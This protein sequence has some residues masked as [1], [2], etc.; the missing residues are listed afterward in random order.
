MFPLFERTYCLHHN[1]STLKAEGSGSLRN[2]GKFLPVYTIPHSMGIFLATVLRNS[3]LGMLHRCL[4]H[5]KAHMH[6]EIGWHYRSCCRD[7]VAHSQGISGEHQLEVLQNLTDLL[8]HTFRSQF[9]FPVLGHDD[10]NPGLQ[11]GRGYEGVANLWRHWLP[12]EAI[13]T[14][15]KGTNVRQYS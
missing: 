15:K 14:F 9:V 1:S 8:R 7:G 5:F 2:A 4:V 11:F 3:N 12:T 10:P 6:A 13:Q